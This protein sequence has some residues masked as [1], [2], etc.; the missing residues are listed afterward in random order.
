MM[1]IAEAF[2]GPKKTNFSLSYRNVSS[3]YYTKGNQKFCCLFNSFL[4]LLVHHF[5]WHINFI[6]I[7]RIEHFTR[8]EHVVYSG[9]YHPCDSDYGSFLASSFTNAFILEFVVRRLVRFHG[10][11]GNL[12]Q[13]R[14]E[15]DT[16]TCYSNRFFLTSRL[17]VTGVTP[18]QQHKRLEPAK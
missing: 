14:F 10:C 5:L 13:C 11:M 7:T 1:V 6:Q 9:E 4:F 15:V 2:N 12:Y 18:A 16:S 17:I 3:F 8:N